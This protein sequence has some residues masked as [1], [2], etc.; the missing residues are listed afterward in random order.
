MQVLLQVEL[1]MAAQLSS[2]ANLAQL[3]I[4]TVFFIHRGV[5]KEN[6]SSGITFFQ[7]NL[8]YI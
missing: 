4:L 8:N 1:P 5:Y 2:G 3:K 7:Q 6:N